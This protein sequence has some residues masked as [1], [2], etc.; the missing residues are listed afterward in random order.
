MSGCTGACCVAFTISAPLER[1][2]LIHADQPDIR[3]MLEPLTQ[4]EAAARRTQFGIP[5]PPDE[6]ETYYRCNHWN[7]TTGQ[8]GIYDHRPDMCSS[9]PGY[10]T[11]TPCEHGCDCT[12]RRPATDATQTQAPNP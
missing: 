11:G 3:D 10:E 7:E 12:D 8:C 2:Q 1:W 4:E 5:T 9:Y 6:S